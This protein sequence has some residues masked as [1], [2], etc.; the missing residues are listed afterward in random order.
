MWRA[1]VS[2]KLLW[3]DYT[4]CMDGLRTQQQ[5]PG[6]SG[7]RPQACFDVWWPLPLVAAHEL[8]AC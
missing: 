1:L 6:C 3:S 5:Q 7:L 4:C 8:L 2:C